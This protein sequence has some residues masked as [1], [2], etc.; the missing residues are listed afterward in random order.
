MYVELCTENTTIRA[1]K[2]IRNL[3]NVHVPRVLTIWRLLMV[4]NTV[5][6]Q[7]NIKKN[8]SS[9]CMCVIGHSTGAKIALCQGL[10]SIIQCVWCIFG[11][12]FTDR[13]LPYKFWTYSICSFCVPHHC[14]SLNVQIPSIAISICSLLFSVCRYNILSFGPV[15]KQHVKNT[16]LM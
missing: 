11:G 6:K 15:Y 7:F 3:T 2:I 4:W 14:L 16:L 1:A 10:I 5:D 13:H 9:M 8:L 12:S